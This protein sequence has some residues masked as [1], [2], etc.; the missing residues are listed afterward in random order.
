M[1]VG[2]GH[3]ALGGRAGGVMKLGDRLIDQLEREFS[4]DPW[5]GAPLLGILDGVTAAQALAHPI[6]TVHSI[7]ELVLH[8]AG[9]KEEVTDRLRGQLA[10]EPA[11]G[12]WPSPAGH[13]EAAWQAAVRRLR[14]SHTALIDEIKRVS[15][16]S[17][18]GAV[19]DERD[20]P[21]GIGLAQWQSLLGILQHDVYHAGQIALIKKAGDS[22]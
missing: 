2:V 5:H 21:L 19:R 1:R 15:E 6:P 18:D 14:A 7:W 22:H 9:W 3:S 17:L 13:D 10:G 20:R 12:D 11:Q 8:I 16:A 4:G